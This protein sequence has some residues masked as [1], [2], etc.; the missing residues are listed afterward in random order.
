MTSCRCCGAPL[1]EVVVDLGMSP[2]ANSYRTAEERDGPETTYPLRP[3]V[4]TDCYLV[5]LGVFES[6]ERMFGD[7]AYF[8]SYSETWMDHVSRY[9]ESMRASLG[10]GPEQLVVEIASNDGHLLGCFKRAG[11][12]VLGIEPARNVA[13][14]A[15]QAGIPTRVSFFSLETAM[16]LR[17]E[18][19]SAD[20]VVAN[21]V[22]AHV[23]EVR[24]FVAGIQRLLRPSGV[25]T[26]EFPHLLRLLQENQFDTIYHEHFSYFSLQTAV[27]LFASQELMVADVEELPTHG[28]SL[29]L[30]VRHADAATP[31][32]RVATLIEREQAAG[33]TS[34]TP[35]REFAGRVERTKRRL[36]AFLIEAR[37][38]GQTVAAYGAPAKGNTLLNYCGI[39]PELVA[40]TV[41]RSPHKQGRYLPGSHLPVFA[42]SRLE[43][44]EPDYVLI[45][46]WNL[47][48]EIMEQMA[49]VRSWGGKFV[50]AVPELEVLT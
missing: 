41:D 17:Q 19:Y 16:A 36:L 22:L 12:P 10:L 50:V 23:P 32:E 8:S 27:R 15:E 30:H 45:L 38:K 42:P 43:E 33:L 11:I 40:Y 47:K 37:D 26:L 6:P 13:R 9:A 49:V 7:Y 18:G 28:G 5:Q 46:P 2:L 31:S 35:Y 48:R 34:L 1:T 24:D 29:R 39:G 21:N 3:W 25:A 4:C 44:S 14:V 20:L